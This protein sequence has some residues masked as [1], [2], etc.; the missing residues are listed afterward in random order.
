MSVLSGLAK[1]I[2]G[3]LKG[4]FFDAVLTRYVTLPTSPAYD[5]ADPPDPTPVN[6]PCKALRD[7]YSAYERQNS[8]IE[9]SDSKIL[10]LAHSLSVTPQTND[11]ITVQGQ[12]FLVIIADTD[13]ATACW[14]VQGRER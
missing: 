4:V 9:T 10:I 11:V 6:Y 14:I 2:H 12:S 8:S 5:P 7:S 1:T 13:P 3:A